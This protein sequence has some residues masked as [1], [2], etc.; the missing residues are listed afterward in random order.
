MSKPFSQELYDNDDK[1]KHL[2]V[3]FLE[4][5]GWDAWVNPDT[6][7]IDLLALDPMGIEY[8]V[9]VEVKHNWEG[10]VFPYQ[11]LHYAERKRKFLKGDRMTLFMTVNHDNTHA[12][13]TMGQD[14]SVAKTII[15]GTSYTDAE[16]FMEVNV[17]KCQLIKL[18]REPNASI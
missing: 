10:S 13:V 18:E 12:L 5:N 17:S 9:E 15:K 3:H 4:A 16:Q 14:L 7:G 11:T 2:V 8:Q 6:Y 1:A